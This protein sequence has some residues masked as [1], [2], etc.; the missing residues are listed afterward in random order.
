MRPYKPYIPQT[1][2]EVWDLLGSMVLGAPRFVDNSGYFPDRNIDT[3]F[4][5]LTGGFEAIGKRLGEARYGKLMELAQQ[6]KALFAETAEDD[7]DRIRA[8]C[9]LLFEMEDILNE[10]RQR[11]APATQARPA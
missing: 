2:G 11:K 5:A 1:P 3:E 9:G 7:L 4:E 6:A 10:V 8:G